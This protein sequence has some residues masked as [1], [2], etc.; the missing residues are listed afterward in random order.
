MHVPRV[1]TTKISLGCGKA[2]QNSWLP[3]SSHNERFLIPFA[4]ALIASIG[5]VTLSILC[6]S[7]S[8]A[9]TAGSIHRN[10]AIGIRT[11]G[12]N[13]SDEAW[14]HGHRE[15]APVLKATGFIIVPL[16]AVFFI[17]SLAA[18]DAP[19][20]ALVFGPLAYA[21]AIGGILWGTAVAHKAAQEINSP[22][23]TT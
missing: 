7:L 11:R 6:L 14:V 13:K 3:R 17:S 19:L 16:T 18:E 4:A 1:E 12:T 5:L 20:L 22:H 8:K 15:A 2:V 21:A 23:T 10:S 9:A